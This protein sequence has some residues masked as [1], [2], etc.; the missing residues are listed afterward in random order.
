MRK[1]LFICSANLQR[2]PTAERLFQ[3]WNGIWE[4]RSAGIIAH[5]EGNPLTQA[6]IDW[7]DLIIAMEPIHIEH[8]YSQFDCPPEKLRILNIADRYLRDDPALI[9]ELMKK[10]P[11]L[12]GT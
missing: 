9:R 11:P 10:V 6:L 2:S 12:L 7:A 3:N 4:T 1:V 8:I 5:A